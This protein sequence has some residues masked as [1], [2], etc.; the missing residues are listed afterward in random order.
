MIEDLRAYII[1]TSLTT[2]NGGLYVVK[3]LKKEQFTSI[4]GTVPA[5]TTVDRI[6]ACYYL[7]D[8]AVGT[9]LAAMGGGIQDKISQTSRMFWLL[10]TL[11]NPVLFKFDI[12]ADLTLT[13]G[14]ATNAFQFKTGAGG[15]LVG[16]ASQNNNGRVANAAHGPGVGVDCLYFATTTRIY[17]TAALNTIT[18]GSTS[19]LIDSM[20]EVP[21][22][23]ASTFALGAGM[24]SI[25]YSG[26]LDKFLVCSS[27]AAGIRSYL[28]QY[29]TDAGQMDRILFVDNKQIDQ[30][31]AD[32]TIS[33]VPAQLAAP[34]SSW[35]EGG[36]LY[37]LRVGA[38]AALNQL[39]TVPIGVD[40]EFINITNSR[41]IL[42]R[43]ATANASKYIAAFT[44]SD[45]ILGGDTG[46]N[47]GIKTE[48]Y[49]I[50]YRTTGITDNS[51][52]WQT[53]D[54]SGD[55]SGV[56]GATHIQL[57]VEF[58][59]GDSLVPARIL[60]AA[61]LYEDNSM[62]DYW[63]GSSNVGT[64]LVNKRFGFRHALAYGTAVPRLAIE[65]F[66]AETG[67]S[68]GTDDSTTKAWTWEKTTN[69]G[70]AWA[71]YNTT[72]RANADTYIRVTPVSLADNIKVRAVL[73]EY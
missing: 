46:K 34:F 40:W 66:D 45:L 28:T 12:Y 42:P 70:G 30:G 36:M 25:E 52:A 68:L 3:G 60:S 65:L 41:L 2:S 31:L 29:R 67:S 35:I 57:C 39:Y 26:F 71:A 63:Q 61:V 21:P 18:T 33:P 38:T 51:G 64:D 23:G 73:R 8:A 50:K 13:A 59:M 10:E 20:T 1:C 4:G 72:D 22:G 11:A 56:S 58:R 47:I 19:W 69:A 16:T 5:A 27:G 48:P 24:N 6:R 55:I 53:I 14:A 15:V 17:R 9:A 62:S 32:S 43:M 54:S 7:K 37:L 44:S 49:R